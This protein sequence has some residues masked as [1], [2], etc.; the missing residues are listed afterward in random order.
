M[1]GNERCV[2]NTKCQR[3]TDCKHDAYVC[4]MLFFRG[5]GALC[6]SGND[7]KQ[8]PFPICMLSG[9][10]LDSNIISCDISSP[11]SHS[12]TVLAIQQATT[13]WHKLQ[14]K[15]HTYLLDHE[16]WLWLLMNDKSN[17]DPI[18]YHRLGLHLALPSAIVNEC[19]GT[20]SRDETHRLIGMLRSVL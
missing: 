2:T 17:Y 16:T 20:S 13:F 11:F 18:S 4:S 9:H 12:T 15:W 1:D 7:H 3:S 5:K 14:T 6:L 10:H 8:R 19:N